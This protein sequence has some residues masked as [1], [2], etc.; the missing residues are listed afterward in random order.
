MLLHGFCATGCSNVL[1]HA[2]LPSYCGRKY[3][4]IQTLIYTVSLLLTLCHISVTISIFGLRFHIWFFLVLFALFFSLCRLWLT[5][6]LY[7]LSPIQQSYFG[8]V[9][10]FR[11]LSVSCYPVFFSLRR[12]RLTYCLYCLSP[13]QQSY[14][15]LVVWF[16]PL[17]VSCYPAGFH[18]PAYLG[19]CYNGNF[20]LSIINIFLIT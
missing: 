3:I 1:N 18:I 13:I 8:L 4:D 14:F 6:C 16:R 2:L 9:V 19:L 11:P 17:S 5:Y 15:G 10:W 12:L 20:L 7:C